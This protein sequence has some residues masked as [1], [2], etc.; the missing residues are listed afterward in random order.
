MAFSR[1]FDD[2]QK[3]KKRNED[4]SFGMQYNLNVPGPGN[5]VPLMNDPHIRMQKWGANMMTNTVHV[6]SDLYGLSRKLNHGS[7]DA[8][9]KLYTDYS[10]KTQSVQFPTISSFVEESRA[11]HPAWMYRD[12]EQSNWSYPQLNPQ[13]RA[14]DYV[15]GSFGLARGFYENIDTRKLEQDNHVPIVPIIDFRQIN[16]VHA[17]KS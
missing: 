2:P 9:S 6:E 1:F 11:S 15:E 13:H 7:H 17:H 16:Y 12:L 8:D 14:G 5:H 4:S 10:V 3:I